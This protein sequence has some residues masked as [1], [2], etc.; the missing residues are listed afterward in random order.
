MVGSSR[1]L[2]REL[3]TL[4]QPSTHLKASYEKLLATGIDIIE[5]DLPIQVSE[6]IYQ[7]TK[8]PTHKARFFK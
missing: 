5:T 7:N 8:V 3:K 6:L 1:Y 4:G 2:D